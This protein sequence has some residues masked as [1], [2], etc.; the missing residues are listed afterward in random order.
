MICLLSASWRPRKHG[1]VIQPQSEDLRTRRAGSV[2][3][4][5]R[6][7]DEMPQDNSGTGK[8]RGKF[9]IPLLFVTF[10]LQ[11]VG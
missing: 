1:G 7:E 3:P 2:K 8:K 11:W 10:N 9:L 4:S 6:A 5:L